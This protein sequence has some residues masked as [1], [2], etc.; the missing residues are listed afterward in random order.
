MDTL[1][2]FL[3]VQLYR[4]PFPLK[5]SF[6]SLSFLMLYFYSL[7]L[8][9]SHTFL[10]LIMQNPQYSFTYTQSQISLSL[11]E[12]LTVCKASFKGFKLSPF[13]TQGPTLLSPPFFLHLN[14]QHVH[15]PLHLS[16]FQMVGGGAALLMEVARCSFS[17][18]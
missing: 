2:L 13:H 4:L 16:L 18:F 1:H 10:V 3:F 17:V 12:S 9:G 11:P 8:N 7:F 5:F 14:H 15:R 6:I